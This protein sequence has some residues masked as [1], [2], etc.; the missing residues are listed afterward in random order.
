MRVIDKT[1]GEYKVRGLNNAI[2]LTF[3]DALYAANGEVAKIRVSAN[4]TKGVDLINAERKAK[5]SAKINQTIENG[6][7]TGITSTDVDS[8]DTDLTQDA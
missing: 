4:E 1:A 2:F 3:E 7:N 6:E 8:I 5:K